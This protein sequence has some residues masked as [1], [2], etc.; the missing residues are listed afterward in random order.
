MSALSDPKILLLDEATSALD[1]ESEYLVKS[2]LDTLIRTS[3][4]RRTV[5]VIAHRLSTVKNADRVAVIK[6]GHVVEEGSHEQLVER[7]GEY[8]RLVSRQLLAQD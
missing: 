1:A 4:H 5:L 6:S 7:N 8:K 3:A 2:A